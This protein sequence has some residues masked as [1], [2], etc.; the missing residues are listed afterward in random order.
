MLHLHI[1]PVLEEIY[2]RDK[3]GIKGPTLEHTLTHIS[4]GIYGWPNKFGNK[5]E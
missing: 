2:G 1:L 5:S 4:M 3:R